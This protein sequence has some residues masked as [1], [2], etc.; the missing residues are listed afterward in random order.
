MF[1]KKIFISLFLSFL[2]A[3]SSVGSVYHVKQTFKI[4]NSSEKDYISATDSHQ[5]HD[6]TTI[7]SGDYSQ[8]VY[9]N[10]KL[11]VD[12]YF[13]AIKYSVNVQKVTVS[14]SAIFYTLH[15]IQS[16]ISKMLYPFH[17]FW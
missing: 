5:T 7:K 6:Y 11:D 4:Y 16:A 2:V 15:Y 8:S 9:S 1:V 13:S 3:F 10:V 14:K 17:S 12:T